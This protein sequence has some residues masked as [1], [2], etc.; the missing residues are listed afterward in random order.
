MNSFVTFLKNIINLAIVLAVIIGG[1]YAYE[2]LFP[3]MI[4]HII[5]YS[6]LFLIILSVIINVID[7]I[8][9]AILTRTYINNEELKKLTKYVVDEI[10]KEEKEKQC[11]DP[12]DVTITMN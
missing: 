1:G 3:F 11:I 2:K 8:T 10:S 9:K 6:F 4:K 7:G 5:L 12:D